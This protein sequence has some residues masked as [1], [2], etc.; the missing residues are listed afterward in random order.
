[1]DVWF[2]NT[3]MGRYVAQNEAAFLSSIYNIS[4]DKPSSNKAA[5]G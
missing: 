5:N 1:M 2:E 3:A 4:T